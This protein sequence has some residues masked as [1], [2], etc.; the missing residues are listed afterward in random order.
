MARGNRIAK[1]A[2]IFVTIAIAIFLISL[3]YLMSNMFY[4]P[5]DIFLITELTQEVLSDSQFQRITSRATRGNRLPDESRNIF[6]CNDYNRDPA[7]WLVFELPKDKIPSFVKEITG[8]EFEKLTDGI[9]SKYSWVN[10]GPY[11]SRDG[12]LGA[13]YWDLNAV[14]NGCRFENV[15][16]YCGV[17]IKRG[18]IFLCH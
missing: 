7:Y 2:V 12:L 15:N 1:I 9:S 17:D 13:S 18:K 14:E 16:F 6:A 5:P 10:K 3:K 11:N 8:V 4:S